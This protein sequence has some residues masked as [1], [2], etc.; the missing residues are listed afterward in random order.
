MVTEPSAG[1]GGAGSTSVAVGPSS[2][3][4]SSAEGEVSS[5]GE[6][7]STGEPQFEGPGCTELP[8]CDRGTFEGHV[9]IES[10]ED[11][12]E[13]SGFTEVTGALEIMNSQDLVCLDALAC[14]QVVGRDVRI[15]DNAALRSTQGLSALREIG[16]EGSGFGT[17]SGDIIV[18]HNAVLERLAGFSV[19]EVYRSVLILEN[20]SLRR[21]SAF[22]E[23]RTVRGLHVT[24]NSELE[25]LGGLRDVGDVGLCYVSFNGSLCADEIVAVCGDLEV[26]WHVSVNDNDPS[27]ASVPAGTFEEREWSEGFECYVPGD[28]CPLGQKCMPYNPQGNAIPSN[29]ACRPVVDEPGGPYE[30]CS[31]L[32]E[33]G[34]GLD[35]CERHSYCRDGECVPMCRGYHEVGACLSTE[36]RCNA[37]SS[38]TLRLCEIV[39][40]PILQ[41]CDAGQG[42]YPIDSA[43]QCAPVA[44]EPGAGNS[45]EDCSFINACNAGLACVNPDVRSDCSAEAGGCCT[46]LCDVRERDCQPG[47]ACVPWYEPFPMFPTN[48]PRHLENV[49]VCVDPL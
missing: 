24:S 48:L 25:S 40:D 30:A 34:S 26:P 23:L 11:L 36:A 1:T 27:C 43:Y 9:R 3:G 42:C 47:L 4:G 14:L 32:G 6:D 49:G 31:V 38:G 46:E 44:S 39:C 20:P 41:N 13:V 22:R 45:G 15:Q 5:G 33:Q 12:A 2:S 35:T 28:A 18:A 37:N 19:R 17:G 10:A 21:V 29:I 7:A 8:V 16:E